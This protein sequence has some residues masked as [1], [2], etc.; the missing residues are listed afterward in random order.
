MFLTIFLIFLISNITHTHGD[1]ETN[2]GPKKRSCY[3]SRC[4]WNVNILTV[5]N[6][7]KVFLLDVYSTMRKYYLIC[8]S[9]TYFG[10]LVKTDDYSIVVCAN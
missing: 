7:L 6:I 4:D 1:V 8:I 2:S 10:S 3:F 5:Y 9:E